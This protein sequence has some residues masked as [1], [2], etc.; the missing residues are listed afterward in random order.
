M[1][2]NVRCVHASARGRFRTTRITTPSI[3]E[4]G[5]DP[6]T[7][8]EGLQQVYNGRAVAEPEVEP[9]DLVS[10]QGGRGKTAPTPVNELDVAEERLHPWT[11]CQCWREIL[12]Y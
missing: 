8:T 5:A 11:C 10:G 12:Y 6:R 2:T 1:G 7:R 4:V 3:I 9:D